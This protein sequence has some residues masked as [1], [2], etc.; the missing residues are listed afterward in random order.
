MKKISIV[1]PVF[2]NE[3]NLS[4]LVPRLLDLKKKIPENKFE[5]I[6]DGD[7]VEHGKPE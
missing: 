4:S 6:L 2:N 1:I 7:Q 5:F 3:S